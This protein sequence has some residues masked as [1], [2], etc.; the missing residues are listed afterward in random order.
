MYRCENSSKCISKQRLLDGIHDCPFDD[1]ETFNRSCSLSDTRQRFRCAHNGNEKC[2]ASLIVHDG[3]IDCKYGEDE[4]DKNQEMIKKHI[5]FQTICDGKTELLPV[6]IDGQNETDETQCHNWPCN[7]TYSRC[8]QFWLCNDGA[9]EVNCPTST[10]PALHHECVFPNDTSKV[11][12]L[13][14]TKAHNGVIDCLGGTDE[15]GRYRESSWPFIR[16]DFH[17]WNS[18]K[19]IDVNDLCN[20]KKNCPFNDDEIFCK[21][22]GFEGFP[23]CMFSK[24]TLVGVEE[25]LCSFGDDIRRD[26]KVFLKLHNVPTYPLQLTTNETPTT[27]SIRIKSRSTEEN[28]TF[29]AS[30]FEQRQCNLGIPVS[31]RVTNNASLLY[32]LCP[33]S[34][35]GDICQ[36][37]N[38][39]IRKVFTVCGKNQIDEYR[40]N[41]NEYNPSDIRGASFM[42]ESIGMKFKNETEFNLK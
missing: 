7:N 29:R 38:Q 10:C 15:R 20:R 3:K 41:Y 2:F 14:I 36:Y 9:D 19:S 32:C 22:F 25:F 23:H 35:Y 8:D 37:Q 1:D 34:Y 40:L 33:P 31:L 24:P 27:S 5:Y 13:P 12:C 11:S 21:K 30:F 4:I 16:H 42:Y 18:T 6:L 28:P 17:C 39:R 26:Q